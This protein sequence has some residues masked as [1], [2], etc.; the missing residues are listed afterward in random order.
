MDSPGRA[1]G[2]DDV[3][4]AIEKLADLH[5]RGILTDAEFAAKKADLLERL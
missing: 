1:T 5:S 2:S 3:I 4:A